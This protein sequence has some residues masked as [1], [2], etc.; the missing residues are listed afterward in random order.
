MRFERLHD[1][2]TMWAFERKLTAP[3]NANRQYMKFQEEAGELAKAIL[4]DNEEEEKDAFG[5]VLVTLI[6]LSIQRRLDIVDCLESAYNEIKNRKGKTINGT[7]I[8]EN[9]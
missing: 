4:Q 8:K 5:D 2:V 9:P 1:A 7:F 6:I 3:E